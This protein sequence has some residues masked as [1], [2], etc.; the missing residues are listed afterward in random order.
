MEDGDRLKLFI[1]FLIL[2]VGALGSLAFY[3]T[4]NPSGQVSTCEE[5]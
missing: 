2:S 1:A 5:R 3:P 4:D